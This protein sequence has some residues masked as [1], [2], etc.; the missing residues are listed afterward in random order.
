MTSKLPLLLLFLIFI[1]PTMN[2]STIDCTH[3]T[4][5]GSEGIYWLR[6]VTAYCSNF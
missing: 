4:Y 3:I 5:N 2:M 6:N 1:I